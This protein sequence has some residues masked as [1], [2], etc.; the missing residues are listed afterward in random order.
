MMKKNVLIFIATAI[1]CVLQAQNV[2]IK[3]GNI[4][5]DKQAVAKIEK[6]DDGY[7]I[8]SLDDN[9]WFIANAIN[10]TQNKNTAPKYWLELTGANGN[11]REVEYR[12]I[13]FTISKE[14]WHIKALLYSDTG[15]LTYT[16]VDQTTVDSFFETQ[17]RQIS[18]KWD[19]I[20]TAQHAENQKEDELAKQDKIIIDGKTIKRNNE[21]VGYIQKK[22]TP[23]GSL[24]YY[25]YNFIDSS[26]KLI[27]HITFYREENMNRDGLFLQLVNGEKS[28]LNLIDYS[29]SKINFDD[30]TKRAVHR[31]YALGFLQDAENPN[32]P[33][34]QNSRHKAMS[35]QHL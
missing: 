30:L 1:S 24:V 9:S 17:D 4:L 19:Q 28:A 18:E 8:S 27:A 6:V 10:K 14:K 13:P 25:T 29:F 22:E 21:T 31:L 11:L 33:K 20:I 23:R 26:K 7:K 5:I 3:K 2:K 16:G 12:E 35:E 32:A 15:L 34:Y